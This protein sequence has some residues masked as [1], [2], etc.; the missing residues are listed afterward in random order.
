MDRPIPG[1]QAPPNPPGRQGPAPCSTAGST[2]NST[3]GTADPS[4]SAAYPAVTFAVFADNHYYDPALGTEGPLFYQDLLRNRDIKLL[5]DSPE[6]LEQAL[7][8]VTALKVDFLLICGDLT[9]DGEASSHRLLAEKLSE[10]S[11][12]GLNILVINGNHDVNN[13]HARG[14]RGNRRQRGGS[15]SGPRFAALYEGQGYGAALERDPASLS[16]LAEP[17]PGLWVL[18]LDTCLWQRGYR[19][20]GRLQPRTLEWA[21]SLLDRARLE[22]K[23]LLAMMHHGL[24]EHYPGNKKFY[25]AYVIDDF[26]S[27]AEILARGGVKVV[28]TGHFHSQDIA[29][30]IT[31]DQEAFLYDVETGSL[32]TYPCPYRIVTIDAASQHMHIQTRRITATAGRRR[33]FP[34]HAYRYCY[35]LAQGLAERKLRGLWVSPRDC[36]LLAPQ[37]VAAFQVHGLGNEEK[38]EQALDLKG[39]SPWGRFVIQRKRAL[40]EA[41][42]EQTPPPDNHLGIDLQTGDFRP[43]E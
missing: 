24:L 39:V 9:K 21:E 14:Y 32:A 8:E 35:R 33:G 27:I 12:R 42:W 28:F 3:T 10:Y 29:R 23:A 41:L 25:S 11:R 1:Q 43:P 34:D 4:A 19:E 5:K 30:L 2:A 16:Y 31:G 6:I 38:A 40:L 36:R 15:I 17:V 7:E 18:C 13:R 26:L 22:G 20:E 37:V